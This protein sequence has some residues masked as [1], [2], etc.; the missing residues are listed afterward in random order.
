MDA[1]RFLGPNGILPLA[2][3]RSIPLSGVAR[4]TRARELH[5]DVHQ[6][7]DRLRNLFAVAEQADERG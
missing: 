2:L 1:K 5:P 7:F 3:G 4:A 6:L